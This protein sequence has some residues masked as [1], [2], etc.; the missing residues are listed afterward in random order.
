MAPA[1]SLQVTNGSA[2]IHRR[3]AAE[4]RKQA[5]TL[6]AESNRQAA[7]A[8]AHFYERIGESLEIEAKAQKE[9]V[10]LVKVPDD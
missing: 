10:E 5:H 9:K 4:M 1:R 2:T 6:R 3:L 8:A 7:S